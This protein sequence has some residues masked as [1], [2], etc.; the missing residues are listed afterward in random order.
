MTEV[1]HVI[2]ND[3]LL[4]SSLS[5]SEAHLPEK[6]RVW[7]HFVLPGGHKVFFTAIISSAQKHG[8][9]KL[10]VMVLFGVI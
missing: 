2:I 9:S 1:T 8:Q 4:L 5:I 10:C 3:R 7:A 6:P